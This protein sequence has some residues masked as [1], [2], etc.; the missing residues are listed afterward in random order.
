MIS[1]YHQQE[2]QTNQT[3]ETLKSV[4]FSPRGQKPARC[5]AAIE[6]QLI[7][8]DDWATPSTDHNSQNVNS[9]SNSLHHNHNHWSLPVLGSYQRWMTWMT[10]VVMRWLLPGTITNQLTTLAREGSS[11]TPRSPVRRRLRAWRSQSRLP[12]AQ[13]L[14]TGPGNEVITA[15]EA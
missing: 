7:P 1:L 6:P 9:S 5:M 3:I 13:W 8:G 14:A 12:P 10:Q 11:T 15:I 2:T 4:C